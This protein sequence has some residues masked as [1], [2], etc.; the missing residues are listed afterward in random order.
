MMVKYTL[1]IKRIVLTVATLSFIGAS[2]AHADDET[3]RIIGGLAVGL[4]GL[5][6]EA[7]ANQKVVDKEDAHI[8]DK[9]QQKKSNAVV[10]EKTKNM[11]RDLKELGYYHGVVDGIYGSG[12]QQAIFR[13]EEENCSEGDN[14]CRDGNLDNIDL[15]AIKDYAENKR[16]NKKNTERNAQRAKGRAEEQK[17]LSAVTDKDVD[18]WLNGLRNTVNHEALFPECK[19]KKALSDIQD[20]NKNSA[21]SNF[22]NVQVFD[23]ID[24]TEVPVNVDVLVKEHSLF[25]F[26]KRNTYRNIIVESKLDT[27]LVFKDKRRLCIAN[28]VTNSGNVP[29]QYSFHVVEGGISD[30]QRYYVEYKEIEESTYKLLN[31]QDFYRRLYVNDINNK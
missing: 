5:A 19:S 17:L 23:L 14:F 8:T 10:S 26:K 6:L 25:L 9:R 31:N 28:A 11:Q 3:K 22:V 30:D 2:Q 29:I 21:Y 1:K 24:A 16:N 15:D 7:N 12:T 13:F 27:A 4:I 20:V 18:D